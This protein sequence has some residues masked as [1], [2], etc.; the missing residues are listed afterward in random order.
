MAPFCRLHPKS[1]A[2]SVKGHKTQLH[3]GSR[4][5]TRH[6]LL[7]STVFSTRMISLRSIDFE[8]SALLLLSTQRMRDR[9]IISFVSVAY[10]SPLLLQNGDN[11]KPSLITGRDLH[12]PSYTYIA[13]S[14]YSIRPC[15]SFCQT[16][17]PQPPNFHDCAACK[18]NE[19][20]F[21]AQGTTAPVRRSSTSQNDLGL[22]R[23]PGAVAVVL[24]ALLNTQHQR[25][26]SST[27]HSVR[28]GC[29]RVQH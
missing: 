1:R 12:I 14:N 28:S 24:S 17:K 3:A 9:M 11:L 16:L 25:N 8:A 6:V 27:T 7:C 29:K 19:A 4:Q 10:H 2:G 22:H 13:M 21:T 26:K 23:L 18:G 20:S 15:L 5:R